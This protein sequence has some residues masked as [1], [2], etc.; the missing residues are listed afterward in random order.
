MVIRPVEAGAGDELDQATE[1]RLVPCV[2]PDGYGR[3]PAVSA[4]APFADQDADQEPASNPSI[5]IHPLLPGVVVTP[6]GNT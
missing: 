4:E 3:L 1:E 5:V 6:Y 2:H